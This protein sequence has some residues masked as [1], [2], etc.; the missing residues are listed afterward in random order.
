MF[1]FR[2]QFCVYFYSFNHCGFLNNFIQYQLQSLQLPM[3]RV[4]SGAVANEE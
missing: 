2:I 4:P 1:N 3:R